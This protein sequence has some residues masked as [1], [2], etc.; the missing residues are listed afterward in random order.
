MLLFIVIAAIIVLL[1][2]ITVAKLNPFI[3][4]LITSILVGFATGMNLPDI[5]ASMKTGLGNT[6]SL[7]AIVLAL[8]TMLGKM[9]AESGGAERI[10]HTLIGRFGK[11]KVH[12]AMMAVAFIVGIPVFF[13]VGFVLL[14]PLLFT[15]AIET[16]VS[17]AHQIFPQ[18]CL[19]LLLTAALHYNRE[20]AA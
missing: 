14:V 11:K 9:M 3:S 17:L 6:L 20:Q 7:L 15:I 13:Q 12:W 4:L 8:G 10:A 19:S 16:G 2:L 18:S 5:I 1:L